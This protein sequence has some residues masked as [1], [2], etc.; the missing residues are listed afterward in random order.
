MNVELHK[1]KKRFAIHLAYFQE[2][3]FEHYTSIRALGDHSNEP[4]MVPLQKLPQYLDLNIDPF[5][6]KPKNKKKA[7]WDE[8]E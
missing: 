8:D 7:R 3:D 6:V 4:G 1:N 2:E 5:E